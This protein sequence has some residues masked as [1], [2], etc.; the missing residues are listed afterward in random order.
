MATPTLITMMKPMIVRVQPATDS[1]VLGCAKRSRG[2]KTSQA[3]TPGNNASS[4]LLRPTTTTLRPPSNRSAP[5]GPYAAPQDYAHT[6]TPCAVERMA[7]THFEDYRSSTLKVGA[8][9]VL[10]TGTAVNQE[11]LPA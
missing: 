3:N 9:A 6:C 11:V 8:I 5:E 1:T 4:H 7:Y 10:A 2:R